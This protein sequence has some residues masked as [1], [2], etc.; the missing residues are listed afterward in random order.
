MISRFLEQNV[1]AVH[2]YDSIVEGFQNG[3]ISP[4][5]AELE[6]EEE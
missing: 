2:R 4:F 6:C 5:L 1:L 3:D